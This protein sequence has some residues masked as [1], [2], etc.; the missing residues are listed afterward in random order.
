[1]R[2]RT[3]KKQ[4]WINQTEEKLLKEKSKKAGLTEA[5]FIRSC[6]KGYKIKEQP[7]KEIIEFTRQISGIANN[8][9]QISRAVNIS[10]YVRNEDLE[11]LNSTITKFIRDFQKKI[12]SRGGEFI[13]SN[14]N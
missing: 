1:M 2:Q 3:I 10:R 5:E 9:N 6:I 14:K 4:I 12:F 13:G 8:V 7:T 11:Y